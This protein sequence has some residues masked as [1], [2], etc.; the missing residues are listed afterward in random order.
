MPQGRT[1]T[2]FAIKMA[3]NKPTFNFTKMESLSRHVISLVSHLSGSETGF[4]RLLDHVD[5]LVC[6]VGADG[7]VLFTSISGLKHVGSVEIPTLEALVHPDDITGLKL[8][9]LLARGAGVFGFGS[10][11]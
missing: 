7:N 6:V 10:L 5:D 3:K 8:P 2:L 9:A 1:S 11:R 4:K